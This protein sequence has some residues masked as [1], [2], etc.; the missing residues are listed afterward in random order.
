MQI[1]LTPTYV[2]WNDGAA[3]MRQA[4]AGGATEK[5]TDVLPFSAGIVVD[6]THLY[7]STPPSI[8]SASLATPDA[9]TELASHA[10]S[11]GWAVSNAGV[12]YIADSNAAGGSG[13]GGPS[14]SATLVQVESGGGTP[15]RQVKQPSASALGPLAADATAV[16]WQYNGRNDPAGYGGSADASN[17]ARASAIRKLSLATGEISDFAAVT[18]IPPYQLLAQ[19]S[20]VVWSDMTDE[21]TTI[22]ASDSNGE[23]RLVIASAPVVR[24]LASDD[25][26]AYFAASS[27]GDDFSDILAAPLAGGPVRTLACHVA[28]IYGLRVDETNVYYFTYT[29]PPLIG[30]LSKQ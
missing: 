20:H 15:I 22:W 6:D 4:K 13:G 28:S 10:A 3:I 23:T 27:A 30:R 2:Y 7:W 12:F 26:F 16:Y 29:A 18:V 14:S 24:G 8:Y 21:V 19:G 9:S 17:T 1:A 25:E 11:V 5:V